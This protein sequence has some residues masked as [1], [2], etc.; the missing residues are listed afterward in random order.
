VNSFSQSN[1]TSPEQH[2]CAIAFLQQYLQLKDKGR[3][4]NLLTVF[5]VEENFNSSILLVVARNT[6][7]N[8]AS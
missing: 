4:H 7:K 5:I 1:F 2:C 3:L 8:N 6:L